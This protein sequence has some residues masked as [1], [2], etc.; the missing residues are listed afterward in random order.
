MKLA[1]HQTGTRGKQREPNNEKGTR[2]KKGLERETLNTRHPRLFFESWLLVEDWAPGG[3]KRDRYANPSALPRKGPGRASRKSFSYVCW[4]K[5]RLKRE[6][7]STDAEKVSY[8]VWRVLW[9]SLKFTF[10]CPPTFIF[11]MK[12]SVA[13]LP[14][15]R[16]RM[17]T[18]APFRHQFHSCRRTL[19][20]SS[21]D[22]SARL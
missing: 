4:N 8:R 9:C 6:T 21:V 22:F 5:K 19:V 12:R 2:K 10:L 17:R 11:T 3:R 7:M 13:L 18:E 16:C 1:C 20:Y 14:V 15:D